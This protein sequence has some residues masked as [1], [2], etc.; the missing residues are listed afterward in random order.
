MTLDNRLIKRACE[1]VSENT[2]IHV[3]AR[4]PVNE[5]EYL[6]LLEFGKGIVSQKEI[7]DRIYDFARKLYEYINREEKLYH[8]YYCLHA[9]CVRIVVSEAK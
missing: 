9:L 4:F 6:I 1:N 7:N 8:V 3:G 2:G 5:D